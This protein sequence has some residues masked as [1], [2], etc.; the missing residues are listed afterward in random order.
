MR[1]TGLALILIV[2]VTGFVCAARHSTPD[3]AKALLDKAVAHYKEVGRKQA[4]ADFTG[5]KDPW[6][7]GDLY[8]AC[9]DSK[10]IIQANG[11]FPNVIGTST[12]AWKDDNGT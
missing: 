5:K 1:K 11:A 6:V 9:Q 10:H 2:F 7:N 4:L 8:V 3:Q 12:D